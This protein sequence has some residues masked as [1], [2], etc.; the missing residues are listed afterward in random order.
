MPEKIVLIGAGN[1]ATQ[2]GKTLRKQGFSI[3]QVYSRTTASASSLAQIL[4]VPYTTEL[5]S[6]VTDADIYIISVKDDEI[7]S[8]L[9]SISFGDG[10]YV[11][12][13][14]SISM[15]VFE[16]YTDRY[17]VFY[18]L[19]TFSKSRDVS[20]R[21][22][23]LLLETNLVEDAIILHNLASRLSDTVQILSS[24]QRQYI[25]LSAAFA[26]NFTNHMYSLAANI[27]EKQDMDYALLLPLIEETAAKVKSLSPKQAQ[28]GPAIRN[29]QKVMQKHLNL[30][31]DDAGLKDIYQKVSSSI[32]EL[33]TE[34]KK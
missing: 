18:P 29:D 24:E 16:Q 12:T 6:I 1:V 5:D 20:F 3:A 21:K 14:G 32:Q 10:L 2:L 8:I 25:H 23:P 11:H 7:A 34:I 31:G 28:T 4:D 17:G 9:A 27:L 19:Q 33:S 30:L 22:I 26:C 15:E 13:A